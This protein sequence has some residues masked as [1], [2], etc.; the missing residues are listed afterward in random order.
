M[1]K[2]KKIFILVFILI[3]IIVYIGIKG[4][5]YYAYKTSII[6][7]NNEVLATKKAF[8]NRDNITINNKQVE[9]NNYFYFEN[10]KIRNVFTVKNSQKN[11]YYV[12]NEN[13]LATFNK[14]LNDSIVSEVKKESKKIGLYYDLT[15][16]LEK[17]NI[18]NNYQLYDY[19]FKNVNRR[20]NI[21]SSINNLRKAQAINLMTSYVI[22]SYQKI[23]LID[24]D[25]N[26]YI[27]N[28]DSSIGIVLEHNNF[29]YLINIY[30]NEYTNE[31]LYD[32]LS[33]ISFN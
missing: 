16:D 6:P 9:E 25:L 4:L 3:L 15:K 27:I 5:C 12:K 26:G 21:F 1:K 2:T 19:L 22:S 23:T 10:L 30:N 20:L 29:N 32:L 8:E 18:T 17:N 24:G 7:P 11:L 33:T 28:F 14:E 31:E 13:M